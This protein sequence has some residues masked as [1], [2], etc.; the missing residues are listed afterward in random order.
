MFSWWPKVHELLFG[1]YGNKNKEKNKMARKKRYGSKA[2]SVKFGSKKKKS[3]KS[4][5]KKP[6]GKK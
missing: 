6:K 2:K 4:K 3:I 5:K 1:I